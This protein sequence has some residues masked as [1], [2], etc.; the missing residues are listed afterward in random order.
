MF[1]PDAGMPTIVARLLLFFYELILG[2]S[3]R[4][5]NSNMSV[6]WVRRALKVKRPVMRLA[7]QITTPVLLLSP[8]NDT[9]VKSKPQH[10]FAKKCKTCTIQTVKGAKHSMLTDTDA[11]VKAHMKQVTEYYDI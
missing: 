7:K 5:R 10:R 1:L 2:K 4:F 3:V 9:V 8:Q 11:I 6:G